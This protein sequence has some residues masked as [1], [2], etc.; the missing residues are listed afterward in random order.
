MKNNILEK[1]RSYTKK[2][3]K[4]LRS[5]V[6]LSIHGRLIISKKPPNTK[7]KLL[8]NF[9]LKDFYKY[10]YKFFEMENG[11]IFTDN[12]ENVSIIK[13][14]ELLD[15]FSYQQINGKLVSSKENQVIKTGT[16]K[17]L[18]K[19]KGSIAILSQGSSGYNN[20]AHFILDIV[21]KIKLL[22]LGTK[23]KNIDYFYFSKPNKYQA[24]ILK[25]I[26]ISKNRI[27]DSNKLRFVQYNTVFGVTHPY[28]SKGTFFRSQSK[29]PEWII[30]Y[31]RKKF[32]KK[33]SLKY[34]F[35]KIF[36]DRSDSK[37]NHC[38]LINNEEIKNFLRT[39]NFQII[40]LSNFNFK[41]QINIFNKAKVIIGPHGAGFVN[42]VFCK[43]KTKIIEI[44]PVNHSNDLYRK[45]SKI[46]E[47]KYKSIKLKK[48]KKN[49]KGDIFLKKGILKKY[50]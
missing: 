6:F 49:K 18:K 27:V 32:M 37:F 39:K 3:Y 40:K 38:K 28:Y 46:N 48:I 12:I 45:I 16:P 26:G 35:E 17:F 2:N 7:F 19:L 14:N 47:L 50:I 42:L 41:D 33:I 1:F 29:M 43:K 13:D 34:K 10:K 31:L 11:K 5:S 4:S 36:I 44:K 23:L 25:I 21:P 22:S 9:S 15:N 8:K 24:E 30:F 20:Y